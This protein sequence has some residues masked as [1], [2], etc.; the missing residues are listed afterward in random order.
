M[1]GVESF[2]VIDYHAE[3]RML[4]VRTLRRKFPEAMIYETD[5]ADHA[6]ELVRLGNIAAVITHRTF[7]VEGVDL[8]RQLRAAH[9]DIII[10]MV[11]GI[12]REDA[13]LGAG[14]TS[15]LPYDEWLRIGTVVENHLR[16][17]SDASPFTIF[18]PTAADI[19]EAPLPARPA[20]QP[21]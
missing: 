4:L 20:H 21:S 10:V 13:A 14:A 3:S 15:F 17:R 12:D 1:A 19:T 7:E 11:S 18:D 8:V 9:P 5:D 16:T 6:I 2:V